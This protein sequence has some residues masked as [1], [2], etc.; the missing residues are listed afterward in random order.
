VELGSEL[1]QLLGLF[2]GLGVLY[3]GIRADLK[4]LH[5]K[6]EGVARSSKKTRKKMSAH[7]RR[8]GE[9]CPHKEGEQATEWKGVHV[10][11]PQHERRR[12]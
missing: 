10:Q 1:I 6:V 9:R 12:Q 11:W 2:A 7:A 4:R 8:I 5:L 3:G